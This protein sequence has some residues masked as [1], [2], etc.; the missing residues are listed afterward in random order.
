MDFPSY[1][2]IHPNS[3]VGKEIFSE[4]VEMFPAVHALTG[5]NITS[6]MVT[7]KKACLFTLR[8]SAMLS[9]GAY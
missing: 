8:R 6:E 3:R 7:K 1:G 4:V 2:E 9:A 5:F